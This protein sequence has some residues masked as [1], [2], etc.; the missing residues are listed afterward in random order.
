M[1][2]RERDRLVA[3]L[4]EGTIHPDDAFLRDLRAGVLELGL[5]P[6]NRE[7]ILWLRTLRMPE[8]AAFWAAAVEA[9]AEVDSARRGTM[10]LRDLPVAVSA[11]SH[12]PVLLALSDRE[13]LR[14]VTGVVRGRR[15]YAQGSNI[16]GFAGRGSE[17]LATHLDRLTW[18]DAAAMV[19]ALEALAVPEVV[20]HLFDYA[21]R[22]HLDETTEYGGIIRLDA[23]GR[24]EVVEFPPRVRHHDRRFNAPQ[25]M[26][27]ASYTAIFHFHFHAQAHVNRKYAGPGFGDSNYADNTRANCLVLTFIDRDTLNVD[28][29][30]HDRVVVDLGTITR[31][32]TP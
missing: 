20:V 31:P 32:A 23:Q 16:E 30:R 12:R 17:D 10:A 4:R 26:F 22:D 8:H 18:G 3:L 25:A 27:D 19:I 28:Y 24:F 6:H 15:H 2:Q 14:V 1:T 13:L 5:V 11:K 9:L 29:Y 7:E 21:D